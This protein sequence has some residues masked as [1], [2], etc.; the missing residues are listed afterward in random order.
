MWYNKSS[1]NLYPT[2]IITMT[3]TFSIDYRSVPSGLGTISNG[4]ELIL[5]QTNDICP[6]ILPQARSKYSE[7]VKLDTDFESITHLN[8]TLFKFLT[9][10]DVQRVYDSELW[11]EA[12][13]LDDDGYCS[14]SDYMKYHSPTPL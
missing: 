9:D 12:D 5:V 13:F 2:R 7:I 4:D 1:S 3:K 11:G 8:N 14:L 10:N 6:D